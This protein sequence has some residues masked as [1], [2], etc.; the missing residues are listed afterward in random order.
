MKTGEFTTR[1]VGVNEAAR[2]Y[3]VTK[4][5]RWDSVVRGCYEASS[6]TEFAAARINVTGWFLF[7]QIRGKYDS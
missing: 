7:Q 6:Q 1:G 3:K 5:L 2:I 4:T